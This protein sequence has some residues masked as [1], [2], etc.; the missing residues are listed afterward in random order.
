MLWNQ[1]MSV[2][3]SQICTRVIIAL[4]LLLAVLLPFLVFSDF[5]EHR[6]LIMQE[7]ILWLMPIYYTF[8]IPALVAL[9]ALDR[10]LAS[11]KRG[12]VFTAGNVRYLRII[13][14]SCFAA[15]VVL[16]VST[17]V[18][19]VFFVLAILAAFF[20]I[21]LRAVKNLFAAAVTLKDENDFTI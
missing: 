3:L 19:I 13:S 2:R 18:S 9:I 1:D 6:A 14:W 21:I 7:H 10:L 16:L 4:A 15:A 17:L 11:V 5:F 20:G 8:C 12:E